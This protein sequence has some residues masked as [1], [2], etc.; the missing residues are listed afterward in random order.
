MSHLNNPV[1]LG[2]LA[3]LAEGELAEPAECCAEQTQ[4]RV[5][6]CPLP[7]D[8]HPISE[9]RRG[10]DTLFAGPRWE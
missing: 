1:T 4:L 8:A 9:R 6:S 7:A 5:A 2:N 3:M 10:T